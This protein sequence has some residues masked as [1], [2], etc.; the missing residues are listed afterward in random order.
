V[1]VQVR[2]GMGTGKST[3]VRQLL[4]EHD[5]Q[6]VDGHERLWRCS[7]D[8]YV[9]G[10]YNLDA[11]S[12]GSG[13]DRISGP[14]GRNIVLHYARQVPHLLWESKWGSTEFPPDPWLAEMLPLGLT[15]A[16]LDTPL[17]EAI[18]RVYQRREERGRNIGK[19]LNLKRGR[20]EHVRVHRL[21]ARAP[22]AGIPAV[23]L[24]TEHAVEQ[25]HDLLVSGGWLCGQHAVKWQWPEAV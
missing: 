1:V 21:I 23:T 10:S 14:Q 7:G 16:V 19:P 20:E 8:L 11:V 12:P 2:G 3:L 18:R 5:G 13:G 22:S 4:K 6:P 24:N 25:L 17:D 9:L 15:W